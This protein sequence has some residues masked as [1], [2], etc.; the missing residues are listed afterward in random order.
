MPL[1]IFYI[2]YKVEQDAAYENEELLFSFKPY[3]D[4]LTPNTLLH[5]NCEVSPTQ[6]TR[7]QNRCISRGIYQ[8]SLK[9]KFF[10]WGSKDHMP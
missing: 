2:S 6:V 4:K 5:I 1:V 7:A 3:L 8:Q 9:K 10:D